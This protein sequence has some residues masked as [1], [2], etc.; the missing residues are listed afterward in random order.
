VIFL[1]LKM[2]VADEA[3]G[4]EV[5]AVDYIHKPF[6]PPIVK[7][8]ARTHLLLREA[9]RKLAQQLTDINN[10]PEMAAGSV[11][12]LSSATPKIHGLNIAAQ[13]KTPSTMVSANASAESSRFSSNIP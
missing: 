7:A 10:E 5:R 1:T 6:S 11:C 3:R 2:E 12:H 4:F 9:N 8:R 13:C